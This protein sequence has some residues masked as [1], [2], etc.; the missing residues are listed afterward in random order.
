MTPIILFAVLAG[1]PILNALFMRVSAVFLFASIAIGNFLV[2]YLSDDVTLALNAFTKGQYVPMI[3][4][5]TLLLSPVVLTLFFL[6][7]SLPKSKVFLHILPLVGCGLSVA[8]LA[9]PLLPSAVQSQIFGLPSADV[10]QNSQ[11]LIVSVTAI[12]VLA[13]MWQTYR[14]V[15]GKHGKKNH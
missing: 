5:L 15:E 7:K 3:T 10:F 6:R 9:L 11:D 13:L 8:V 2:I 4:Q 1:L 14:P 12:M